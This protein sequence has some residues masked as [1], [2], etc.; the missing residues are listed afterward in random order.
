MN[1]WEWKWYVACCQEGESE[2]ITLWWRPTRKEARA[3]VKEFKKY[4]KKS[5]FKHKYRI[6]KEEER[7]L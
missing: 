1:D 7:G 3:L 6:G 2:W 5:G 4:D